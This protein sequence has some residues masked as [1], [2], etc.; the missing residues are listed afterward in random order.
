M[1]QLRAPVNPQRG[2]AVTLATASDKVGVRWEALASSP[3]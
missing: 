3:A 1:Q 2:R